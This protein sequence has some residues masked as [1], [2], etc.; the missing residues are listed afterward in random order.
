MESKIMEKKLSTVLL[1]VGL[2]IGI[3]AGW[4]LF[5]G[6]FNMTG[7]ADEI[8]V[9]N[10]SNPTITV[11]ENGE[12]ITTYRWEEKN[13]ETGRYMCNQISWLTKVDEAGHQS[14]V[15]GCS[16]TG[17]ESGGTGGCLI[18]GCRAGDCDSICTCTGINCPNDCKCKYLTPAE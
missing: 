4:L 6:K 8:M 1:G 11:N 18:D 9:G 12:I 16:A 7:N 17:C 14:V 5:N 10:Q 2:L 15:S 13:P 3:F